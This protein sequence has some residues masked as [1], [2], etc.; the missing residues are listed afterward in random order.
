MYKWII[1]DGLYSQAGAEFQAKWN[2]EHPD[3][4]IE[5][6]Y[7]PIGEDA[8]SQKISAEIVAGTVQEFS[9][10]AITTSWSGS[11]RCWT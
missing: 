10:P 9:S 4:P 11:A 3:D 5:V 6:R 7:D 1:Y 8:Y 2:R